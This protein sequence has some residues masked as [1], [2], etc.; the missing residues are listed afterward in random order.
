[1]TSSLPL[2]GGLALPFPPIFSDDKD[3]YPPDCE[4]FV[5]FEA[6]LASTLHKEVVGANPNHINITIYE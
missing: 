4:R 5:A 3:V 6:W 1:M 2:N